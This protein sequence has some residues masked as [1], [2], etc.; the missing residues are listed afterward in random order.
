[1]TPEIVDLIEILKNK[2]NAAEQ[3]A[4]FIIITKQFINELETG[5]E[6]DGRTI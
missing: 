1:M 6:N 2:L 3:T 4:D 5:K